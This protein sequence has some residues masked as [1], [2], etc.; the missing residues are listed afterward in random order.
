MDS[1]LDNKNY[2]Y[3]SKE[4]LIKKI[5]ELASMLDQDHHM[6]R[7]LN[8]L[9][10][11]RGFL[12]LN[13]LKG[14]YIEFGSFRSEMHYAAYHILDSTKLIDK[15]IGLDTFEG[16]PEMNDKEIAAM[17]ITKKGQFTTSLDE[18]Q[19]FVQKY[20]KKKGV[21]IKG[22]FRRKS[23]L[24]QCDAYAPFNVSI[25]DCNLLTS[26]ESSLR[27]SFANI[28]PGGLLFVD[29]YFSNFS[30]GKPRIPDLVN[31][32]AKKAKK[33]LITHSFYPP[34]AKS[35]IVTDK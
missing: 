19:E 8:F 6:E 7:K 35:F 26:L 10:D 23:V 13:Q 1:Q 12:Y 9:L 17:P 28:I 16:E 31:Q 3:K 4:T 30:D 18:V 21:L 11:I 25:V 20:M 32:L 33:R 24:K 2:K 14:S 29:D 15:Y 5:Q 27:Y 34:F 22:D